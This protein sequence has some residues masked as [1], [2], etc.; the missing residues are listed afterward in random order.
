[1]RRSRFLVIL[2]LA[3][4]FSMQAQTQPLAKHVVLIGLD[5]WASHDFGLAHDVPN[6]LYLMQ[7]GSCAM[8]KRSV[9]PSSSGVNWATMFMGAGPEVHGYTTWNSHTPDVK[10]MATNAN[11]IFP[12]IFSL[13]RE[14]RP[15]AETG[16]TFEWDGIKYVI[17][18]LSISHV[19]FFSEGWKSVERNCDHIVQYI[20]DKK[21]MLFAP[22]FDGIDG[23]GHDKG[24]YSEDYYNY[25]ARVDVCIGR[26]I[27]ALKDA[28]I[29]DDTIIIVTG[30]HGG[31]E[32]GHG[33]LALEDMESPYVLFGKNVRSSYSI[34]EP[35]VQYDIAATIA[36]ILGL[37]TPSV[38]RGKPTLEV[39]EK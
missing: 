3:L 28:G 14:Q 6:L 25:L 12:T 38:W 29:F 10:S 39:F 8:H 16:C 21:P 34:K 17:D 9:I 4:S 24:W 36:Y 35:V 27:Q 1:M 5:G 13:V 2:S 26:I 37:E 20:L 33:T 32:K 18:T 30:D 15:N 11:G 19:K 23:T 22:C 31:H 7:E